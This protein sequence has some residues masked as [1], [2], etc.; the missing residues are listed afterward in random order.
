MVAG[1]TYRSIR[2][3]V[4]K[5]YK[6]RIAGTSP[7]NKVYENLRRVVSSCTA[8]VPEAT[9][10]LE[11]CRERALENKANVFKISLLASSCEVHRCHP[12]VIHLEEGGEDAD[13]YMLGKAYVSLQHETAR[14]GASCWSRPQMR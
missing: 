12:D 10:T 11:E 7:Y 1:F 13:I 14:V 6:L 8:P 5:L 3:E 9:L 4:D 2:P